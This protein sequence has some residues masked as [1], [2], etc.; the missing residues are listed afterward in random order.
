MNN[1]DPIE[2]RPVLAPSAIEEQAVAEL[3]LRLSAEGSVDTAERRAAALKERAR[4]TLDD[5]VKTFSDEVIA[6]LI[7]KPGEPR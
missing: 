6:R 1:H 2:L 7:R 3:R 5:D 4:L